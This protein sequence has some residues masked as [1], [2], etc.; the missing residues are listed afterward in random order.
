MWIIVFYRIYLARFL[1]E[2]RTQAII[3]RPLDTANEAYDIILKFL[4]SILT[5]E[6]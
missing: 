4:K 2:Y 1:K 6:N 3:L 5:S